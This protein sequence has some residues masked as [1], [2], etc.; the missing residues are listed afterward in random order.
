MARIGTTSRATCAGR[1][2]SLA[3]ILAIALLGPA[4]GCGGQPE[5][6]DTAVG[7]GPAGG[8]PVGDVTPGETVPTELVV[9]TGGSVVESPAAPSSAPTVGTGTDAAPGTSPPAEAGESP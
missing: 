9:G 3:A 4:A 7:V 5:E 1:A 8:A 6:T 2:T